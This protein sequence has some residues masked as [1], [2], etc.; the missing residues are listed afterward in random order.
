MNN[1]NCYS[2]EGMIISDESVL[3]ANGAMSRRGYVT[4]LQASIVYLKKPTEH[5]RNRNDN[6]NT[7]RFLQAAL[8]MAEVCPRTILSPALWDAN[9]LE[10]ELSG[11]M[12]S[13]DRFTFVD[14]VSLSENDRGK[15][16]L[17]EAETLLRKVI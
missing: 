5:T 1:K 9:T 15:A 17:A 2:R 13:L 12:N 8:H 14:W 16:V 11:K 4:A 3:F 7:V 6:Y 10:I